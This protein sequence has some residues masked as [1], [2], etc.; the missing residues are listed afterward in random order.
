MFRLNRTVALVGMM[1]S[2]K[3][4]LG[5]RLADHLK[6]SFKDADT[7]IEEAAGCSINEI[8]ARFGESAFRDGERR[9]IQRLL[10]D[11]PFILATGGGAFADE[12]IRKALAERAISIWL[13]APLDVLLART[14]KRDSRPLLKNGDP[15]QT[16]KRLMSERDPFYAMSDITIES[17]NRPHQQAID[18]ITSALM[19]HGALRDE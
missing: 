12:A 2:G 6:V 18:E 4:A 17:G 1:G 16:L 10:K 3:S 7:E 11:Q 8:F 13:K 5:R 19:K 9:V 14:S 15:H